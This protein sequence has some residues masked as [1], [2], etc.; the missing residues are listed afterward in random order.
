MKQIIAAIMNF[1]YRYSFPKFRS[2]V[3]IKYSKEANNNKEF[4]VIIHLS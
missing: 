4:T 1:R 3:N 2:N